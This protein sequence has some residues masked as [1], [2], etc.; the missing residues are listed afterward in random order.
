[1]HAD[2]IICLCIWLFAWATPT[3]MAIAS[4]ATENVFS[5]ISSSLVRLAGGH[6]A[7]TFN[8]AITDSVPLNLGYSRTRQWRQTLQI[9]EQFKYN[10]R[11]FSTIIERI[12]VR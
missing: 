5:I 1:M 3:D 12:S 4:I 11:I 2:I 6:D 8:S 10:S 7:E 9:A